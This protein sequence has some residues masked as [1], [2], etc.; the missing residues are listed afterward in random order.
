MLVRLMSRGTRGCCINKE[1]VGKERISFYSSFLSRHHVPIIRSS[2]RLG[3]G[4]FVPIWSSWDCKNY[5]RFL[6][7]RHVSTLE[8]FNL[9]SSLDRIWV[10]CHHCFILGGGACLELLFHG[11]IAKQACLVFWLSKLLY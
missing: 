5:V 6:Y 1:K 10:S 4:N 11:F 3:S 8:I 2:P 9:L 7:S